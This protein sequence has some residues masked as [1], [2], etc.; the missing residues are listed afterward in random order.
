VSVQESDFI[1]QA[2]T[3]TI[4]AASEA[5][6]LALQSIAADETILTA[7]SAEMSAETSTDSADGVSV[8]ASSG[9]TLQIADEGFRF[10]FDREASR[11]VPSSLPGL[12]KL[13]RT[14]RQTARCE[15]VVTPASDYTGTPTEDHFT[16]H[17]RGGPRQ[18]NRDRQGQPL[19]PPVSMIDLVGVTVANAV[20]TSQLAELWVTPGS[21]TSPNQPQ[22][23]PHT[24]SQQTNNPHSVGNAAPRRSLPNLGQRRVAE[25]APTNSSMSRTRPLN[26][27]TTLIR[28]G[29]Q[30]PVA[31]CRTWDNAG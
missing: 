18:R 27:P 15:A 19:T 6:D 25:R 7:V 20:A 23:D 10:H 29:T 21:G 11:S 13:R 1:Y 5:I 26:K 14:R 17:S 22:H 3:N 24:A 12:A 30:P 4:V 28:W 8:S 2:A 31:A 16:F 9:W